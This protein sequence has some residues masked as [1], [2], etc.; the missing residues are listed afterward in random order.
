MKTFILFAMF[1]SLTLC[2]RELKFDFSSFQKVNP[3]HYGDPRTSCQP[4]E[5]LYLGKEGCYCMPL[6]NPPDYKCPQD[7][8]AGTTAVP[9]AHIGTVHPPMV[10]PKYCVLMCDNEGGNVKCPPGAFCNKFFGFC[11]FPP[12]PPPKTEISVLES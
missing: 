7:K 10:G 9:N 3:T 11:M 1:A 8:P 2:H 12:I 4:D 6:A 5:K